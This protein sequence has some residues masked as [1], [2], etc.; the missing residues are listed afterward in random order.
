M[1][2]PHC[3]VWTCKSQIFDA[4]CP[5]GDRFKEYWSERRNNERKEQLQ[6]AKHHYQHELQAVMGIWQSVS[7][8]Y[9][10]AISGCCIN[11]CYHIIGAG[12]KFILLNLKYWGQRLCMANR[13]Q[14]IREILVSGNRRNSSL[15]IL[16][17]NYLTILVELGLLGFGN[18]W[19]KCLPIHCGIRLLGFSS[20]VVESKPRQSRLPSL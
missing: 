17:V 5:F 12:R 20:R 4:M 16:D 11:C 9:F 13:K 2:N 10:I 7:K 3:E 8:I 14:A 18:S 19:C 6:Q 1:N 15:E